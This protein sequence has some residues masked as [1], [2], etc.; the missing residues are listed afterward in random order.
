[1]NGALLQVKTNYS[2]LTSLNDIKKLVQKAKEL[3]YHALAI[4]DYNMF[5]VINFYKECQ[6][7]DIKPIIGLTIIFEEKT[8]LLYAI[9]NLGY[10][11]LIKL[12]TILSERK[13]S[14]EDLENY[15]DNLL[16]IMPLS[17][18]D[19]QLYNIYK[20]KYIGYSNAL[21]KEKIN[22]ENKVYIN[23]ILYLEKEEYKYLD[24]LYMIKEGK[25][26]GEFELNKYKNHH[27]LDP[28]EIKD[29]ID[30]VTLKNIDDIVNLCNVEIKYQSNLLPVYDETID[31]F[32]YLKNLCNKGLN[33]RLEQKVSEIY[34]NRLN[35]EL[36]V[37]NKMGFCNYFLIVWD[38]VKYAKKNNIFVGP[39]RGSAAGSLVSYC[40]GITDIDPIKY[41]LLFERFL[42]SE[43]VT[44][45]DIDID[46]DSEK[47]GE[48]IDYVVNKYGE[49]KV[50]GI[51]TFNTL[52]SK[53]V[54]R[55]VGKILS[56][57]TTMID[58]ITKLVGGNSLKDAINQNIKL[59]KLITSS[60]KLTK[61]YDIA[62]HLE[63]M[64]RHISIHAAGIIMSNTN[65][66]NVIPLYKS[67]LGIYLTAYSM[68]YLEQ[69]G[70]L[71]MDFL[72]IK[73]FTLIDEVITN[74]KTNE[75]INISFN[76]I[77]LNDKKTMEIFKKAK[78]DGIFQFES[79]GMK[80]FLQKL[81]P[82][83]IEDLIA[84][85]ALH[86]PGPMDNID[87]YIKRKNGKEKVTYL[88][89]CLE[90]ILKKTYGI[91]IYQEQIMQI[92]NVL[93]GY[94]LGEADILRRAMSKKKKEVLL[95]EKDKFINKC[96]EKGH[97]LKLAK[98]V[99]E[100]ILKFADYG[101]NRSHAVSYVI[102]AYKMAFLKTHFYSYFM[103]SLLN[104]VIGSDIK[105]KIYL[106]E[107]KNN[108]GK[109][110]LP[111]INKNI[112]KYII[113]KNM[114]RLPIAIIKNIGVITINEI[115]KE[116]EK[117]PFIDFI[118][119]IVRTK[120]TSIN[121]KVI[122]NLIL[123]NAFSEFGYNRKTLI[124]NLDSILNYAALVD[125]FSLIKIEKP[126]IQIY[127]EY[128][129]EQLIKFELE[130]FS[131]YVSNH[132]V[133]EYKNA[134]DL[135]TKDITENYNK[136]IHLVLHVEKIKE[137]ITKQNDVMAFVEASDEYGNISL[138]LFKDVYQQNKDLKEKDIIKIYGK[139]EKRFDKYQIIVQNIKKLY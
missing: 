88:D 89:P 27:L 100:L 118:D 46:F 5:G 107:L 116:Q 7:N 49:K 63:N 136:Y 34:L 37:I 112:D 126:E 6:N 73:N 96:L 24:Y 10:K 57:P 138:I 26:L 129:K 43:R 120:K 135:G 52:A 18:Y 55:D 30:D 58:S 68:D 3:N 101:F 44:M 106:Q 94:S 74:I 77:P 115:K 66:D 98:E 25:I 65:L 132:P 41:D 13:I 53:Q 133:K 105:T 103:C 78:T 99:Y 110:L 9:N 40:L 122:T 39:G 2:I 95:E 21:E 79:S 17:S 8:L 33:K 139:V 104:N 22:F 64:P 86:R 130:I 35:Y 75:K 109:I 62:I 12:S 131:F 29:L 76:K 83:N 11:N 70:L 114:V 123:A 59:R 23:D 87:T 69:L 90:K 67:D 61:L 48:V 127:D 81:N 137:I 119:F 134:N 15:K 14:L 108:K 28:E 38:Y 125:E 36:D 56:L 117:G 85:T 31:A 80:S 71:K 19:E 121:K 102:I 60:E 82:E 4:T 128:E 20:I 42:N 16:L 111:N 91:I 97:D 113:D 47:R 72:G 50:A 124:E 1:M 45:P 32:E 54:I 51:I 92:A 93:A 84:A